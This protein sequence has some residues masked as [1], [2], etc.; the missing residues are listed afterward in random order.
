MRNPVI[1]GWLFLLLKR[2]VKSIKLIIRYTSPWVRIAI[3]LFGMSN[4]VLIVEFEKEQIDQLLIGLRQYTVQ[5]LSEL[6]D[7]IGQFTIIE[8]NIGES[9]D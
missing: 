1:L 4:Q 8:R 2:F 9:C 7:G 5:F 3:R 6:T